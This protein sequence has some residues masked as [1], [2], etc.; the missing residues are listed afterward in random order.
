MK[1][2]MLSP[3]C[4]PEQISSSHLTDDLFQAFS[5]EGV[6]VDVYSPTPCRGIDKETRKK[7]QSIKEQSMYDNAIRIHRFSLF[8][9]NKNSIARA[10]RYILCNII[11]YH[12]GIRAKNIDVIFAGSTPPT[13]GLLCGL[14]KKKLTKKNGHEVPF[15]YNLQDVFPDSLVNAK[16]TTEGSFLW[17]LGRKIENYTYS[18]ADIIIVISKLY[19][20]SVIERQTL[21]RQMGRSFSGEPQRRL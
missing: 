11:Q 21:W 6:V 13:Q 8:A 20:W 5:S 17:K 19:A 7:Y 3:Y 4:Y 14:V 16:M 9:E 12:K 2:L 15:V 18:S 10:I 1:V